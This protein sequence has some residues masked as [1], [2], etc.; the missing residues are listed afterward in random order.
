M[1]HNPSYYNIQYKKNKKIKKIKKKKKK[2]KRGS[3]QRRVFFLVELWTWA[4][5]AKVVLAIRHLLGCWILGETSQR[6]SAPVIKFSQPRAWIYL[7]RV[8]VALQSKE[9]CVISFFTLIIFRS[10]IQFL[11]VLFPLSLCLHQQVV[12]N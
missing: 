7:K 12:I 11:F 4:L 9:Y 6:K 3:W 1:I 8:S 2:K 10:I 5:C